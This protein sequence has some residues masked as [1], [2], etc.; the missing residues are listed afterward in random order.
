MLNIL[1]HPVKSA[2]R[3]K[4]TRLHMCILTTLMS[5][6]NDTISCTVTSS[7]SLVAGRISLL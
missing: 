3:F 5:W 7:E 2:H 6:A 4:H 1:N